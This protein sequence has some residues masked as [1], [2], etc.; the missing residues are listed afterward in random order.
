MTEEKNDAT[1]APAAPPTGVHV[2][3]P[4]CDHDHADYDEREPIEALL[5]VG[6]LFEK[7][8]HDVQPRRVIAEIQR[9]DRA[10]FFRHFKGQRMEKF[11][12]RKMTEILSK[13]VFGRENIFMAQLLMIL[14]NEQH[15]ELY[16]A[17]RD[18]VQ[19]INEDVEAIERIEDDKAREF[20]ADLRGK[21]HTR[22]DIYICVRLNDVRFSEEVIQAE[23]VAGDADAVDAPPEPAA[24]GA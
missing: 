6:A 20:I 3:G 21:G 11:S 4:E 17:M 14:W 1:E 8:V 22:D 16:I 23:L 24:A 18:H 9:G 15:R 12:R 13:E 5:K 2:H 19:T 10:A 7:V